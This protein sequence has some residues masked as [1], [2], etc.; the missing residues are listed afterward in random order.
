MTDTADTL[1]RRRNAHAALTTATPVDRLD[2]VRLAHDIVDNLCDVIDAVAAQ[3]A[4]Q[5]LQRH[6]RPSTSSPPSKETEA[7]LLQQRQVK[8]LEQIAYALTNAKG[9]Q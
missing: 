6:R 7:E 9:I 5:E 2:F 4:A 8:A 3:A 1:T